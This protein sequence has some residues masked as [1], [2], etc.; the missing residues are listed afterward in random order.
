[1]RLLAPSRRLAARASLVTCTVLSGLTAACGD[2]ATD[3]LPEGNP[4]SGGDTTGAPVP[5]VVGLDLSEPM[6]LVRTLELELSMADSVQV[7]YG[8]ECGPLLEAATEGTEGTGKRLKAHLGRLE[9]GA[10]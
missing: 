2:G 6:P 5:R 3:P 8:R 4:P 7:T 10:D 9:A 1:M